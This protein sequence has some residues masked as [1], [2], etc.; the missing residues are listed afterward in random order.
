MQTEIENSK[1]YMDLAWDLGNN[2][3]KSVMNPSSRYTSTQTDTDFL[4][5]HM[6][7]QKTDAPTNV[8]LK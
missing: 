3:I 6:F 4:L 5:C 7:V 8:K 2:V 1:T